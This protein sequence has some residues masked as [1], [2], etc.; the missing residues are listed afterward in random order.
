MDKLEIMLKA[1]SEKKGENIKIIDV[2]EQTTVCNYFIV[3]SA[4]NFS[5]VK[6]MYD[7]VCDKMKK[8]NIYPRSSDGYSQAKWI[9]GDFED[10]IVHLFYH[11]TRCLYQFDAL[12]AEGEN[13]TDYVD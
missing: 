7:N 9:A 10:I 6:A 5:A 1:I 12:W 8:E 11:E 3:A 13:V 4:K 2:R